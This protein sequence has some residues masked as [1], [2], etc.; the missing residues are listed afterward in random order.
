MGGTLYGMKKTTIYLE[1]ELDRAITRLAAERGITKAE[2]I[3]QALGSAVRETTRPR[4]A[5][6][7]VGAG[8]GDVADE[9]DRHLAETGFGEQ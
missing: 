4:I 8:P 2:A 9:V 7:G 6:I 5:A 1:P 3:R